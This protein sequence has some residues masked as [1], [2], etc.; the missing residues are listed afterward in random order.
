MNNA[1]NASKLLLEIVLKKVNHCSFLYTFEDLNLCE[2]EFYAI[3][4]ENRRFL[5]GLPSFKNLWLRL[6]FTRLVIFLVLTLLLIVPSVGNYIDRRPTDFTLDFIFVSLFFLVAL[7]RF[8]FSFRRQLE[9]IINYSVKH[10][11]KKGLSISACEQLI[12]RLSG[13]SVLKDPIKMIAEEIFAEVCRK[14]HLSYDETLHLLDE[15]FKKRFGSKVA[16]AKKITIMYSRIRKR[17]RFL[18]KL[19]FV[20]ILLLGFSLLPEIAHHN[21]KRNLLTFIKICTYISLPFF[22]AYFRPRVWIVR[23]LVDRTTEILQKESL[24]K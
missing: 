17:R 9:L 6:F 12:K 24:K 3:F 23:N 22:W 19:W 11:F 15:L 18:L 1:K 14:S 21:W 20:L 5:I 13:S 8:I 10:T 4:K 16:G 7:G 2:A